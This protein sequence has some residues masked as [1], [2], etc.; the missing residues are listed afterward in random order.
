MGNYFESACDTNSAH[1][2]E[3][4][5]ACL[6]FFR[7]NLKFHFQLCETEENVNWAEHSMPS[8]T[9]VQIHSSWFNLDSVFFVLFS[10]SVV[11]A[12]GNSINCAIQSNHSFA[13]C[14]FSLQVLELT[15]ALAVNSTAV[16]LEWHLLLSDTE[17]YIEVIHRNNLI[18]LTIGASQAFNLSENCV[19]LGT[20][21]Y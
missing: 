6:R 7:G 1:F 3:R 16:R 12:K 20:T 5:V 13:K 17:Y 2:G 19:R 8:Y 9:L 4:K 18:D 10:N 15:D 21:F 14:S 11:V